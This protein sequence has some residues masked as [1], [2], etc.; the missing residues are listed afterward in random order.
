MIFDTLDNI[1]QY[2]ALLP[3]LGKALAFINRENFSDLPDGKV[4]IDGDDVFANIQTYNTKPIDMRGFEAHRTYADIQF[5]IGG[6]G[7]LCGVAVPTEDQ[8]PVVPYDE[9]K[10][11]L[12]CAP[13]ACD[14]IKLTPGYFALFLPQDAHEPGRQFGE[15]AQVRKCVVK[16]RI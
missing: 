14:W 10:D 16:V 7:E 12:F 3:R 9:A 13:V 1:G 5:L 11:V 6:D 15:V 2:T 8:T 4:E